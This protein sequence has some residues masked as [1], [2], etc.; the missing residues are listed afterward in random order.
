MVMST[1]SVKKDNPCYE[2]NIFIIKLKTTEWLE[3]A[4]CVKPSQFQKS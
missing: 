1:K 4:Y 3:Y 2:K